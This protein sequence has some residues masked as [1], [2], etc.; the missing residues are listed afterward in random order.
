MKKAYFSDVEI[1]EGHIYR[2][3]Q[4]TI[5]TEYVSL[6]DLYKCIEEL[7]YKVYSEGYGKDVI[8]VPDLLKKVLET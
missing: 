6:D 5:T 2:E 3:E 7:K 4:L 8:D 1:L